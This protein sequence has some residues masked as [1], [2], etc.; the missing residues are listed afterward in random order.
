MD[1]K[2]VMGLAIIAVLAFVTVATVATTVVVGDFG[3]S[4]RDHHLAFAYH[5]SGSGGNGDP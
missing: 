3:G 1:F 4:S 5:S 2:K